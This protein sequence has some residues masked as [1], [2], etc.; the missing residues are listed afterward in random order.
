MKHFN[1]EK[2]VEPRGPH[3]LRGKPGHSGWKI[4][5]TYH[6]IL[7]VLAISGHHLTR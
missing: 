1:I 3:H 5:G 4:N 7:N 6:S 2:G